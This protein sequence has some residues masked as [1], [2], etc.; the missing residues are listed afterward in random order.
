MM[1]NVGEAEKNGGLL[2]FA[3]GIFNV[4]RQQD[5]DRLI[6]TETWV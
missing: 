3:D 4:D 1:I 5:I 6:P 2:I